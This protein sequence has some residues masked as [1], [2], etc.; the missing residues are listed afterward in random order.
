MYQTK[1]PERN[2]LAHIYHSIREITGDVDAIQ[3]NNGGKDQLKNIQDKLYQIQEKILTNLVED[4]VLHEIGKMQKSYTEPKLDLGRAV[5]LIEEV[6]KKA[7]Q[8]KLSVI[9]AVYNQAAHP[10]AVH[11]MD[12]AYI[13]SYDVAT[14]KAYTS[15]AL[16]MSTAVLK[17]LSQPG[18]EL[19]GIQHTNQ[20]KIV[21]FGGGM[22]LIHNGKIVG[23]I[24]VSGGTEEQDTFLAAYG[25][26]K[27]EEV[28]A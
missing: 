27:L 2:E 12:D 14:N 17:N 28:M 16:K 1:K 21:I 11:C 3:S 22:P 23:A 18:Q 10:I 19:Y 26:E 25:S 8:M 4:M 24:G 13:A 6:E 9:I 5:A 7:A 15:A 20:G